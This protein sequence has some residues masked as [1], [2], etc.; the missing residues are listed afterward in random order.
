MFRRTIKERVSIYSTSTETHVV[1][2]DDGTLV[3]M[4]RVHHHIEIPLL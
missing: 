4:G 3:W 1:I 2:R